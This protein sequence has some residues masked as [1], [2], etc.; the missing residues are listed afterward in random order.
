MLKSLS[1]STEIT[2]K[3]LLEAGCHFGHQSRRWHPKMAEYLFGVKDSVHIFD[4]AKTKTKLEEAVE[5]ARKVASEGGI[6]IF[7]G[8][9]RQAAAVIKEEAKNAGMPYV[10]SRWLGGTMTNWDQIK[11]RL[12]KMKT[13]KEKLASGE[14]AEKYTKKENLLIGREVIKLEKFL[15]GLATLKGIPDA[16]VVVDIKAEEV[17]VKEAIKL[18]IPV[19]AIVDSNS[20]PETVSY[21][22]PA[23]DDSVGSIKYLISIIA[24]AIKDG[25]DAWERK[26]QTVANETNKTTEVKKSVSKVAKKLVKKIKAKK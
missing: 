15:G 16:L 10:N 6:I 14:Y 12:D 11:R 18:G 3:D 22:V 19:I 2:L 5:F 25:K 7:V 17:A 9:K 23:N 4:L 20:N 13:D 24:S 21:P 1:M 26:N 8:C